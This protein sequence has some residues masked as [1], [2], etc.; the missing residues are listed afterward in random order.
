MVPVGAINDLRI[1]I[2]P[3]SAARPGFKAKYHVKYENSGTTTITNGTVKLVKDNRTT[4][5]TATTTPS[6]IVA[7]TITWTFSNLKPL[8]TAELTVELQLGAPPALNNSDTLEHYITIDPATGDSTPLNNRSD[9]KQP[10]TGSYDPNDKT[11]SHGNGFDEQMLVDGE[12]LNYVIRFQNTGNDTAFRVL[13]RDTLNNRMDWN[14]FEMISASHPYTLS[15]TNQ[16]K[17]EWKFDP[18]VLPDSTKDLAASNGYVSFRIKPKSTLVTGDTIANRAGIYFDFNPPVITNK[19]E[20][21]IAP[22]TLARP[23]INGLVAEYCRKAQT[24]TGKI[25]NL[26]PANTGVTTTVKLDNTTLTVAADGSFGFDLAALAAGDHT[27]SV[28]FNLGS[29]NMLTE[30]PF[31]VTEPGVLSLNL[32]ANTTNV[33]NASQS[34]I[35]TG[36][37]A[38]GGTN[39][40]YTYA[41]DRTFT[42]ILQA[43]GSNNIVTIDPAN[44]NQG[45]NWIYGRISANGQC[46]TEETNIDSIQIA[47][48]FVTGVVDMDAPGRSINIYP[49]PFNDH[50]ILKGFS[51]SKKYDVVLVNAQG[52]Q[53]YSAT[54]K[55]RDMHEFKTTGLPAGVY[56]VHLYKNGKEL[57]AVQVVKQ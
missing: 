39:L 51:L 57:G 19:E 10:V 33:T 5:S 29:T 55:N 20:T 37:N 13:V 16:N 27:V 53:L 23:A 49:V 8:Q 48:N 46:Y 24:I 35:I 3:V 34:V 31:H 1:T 26:Q 2:V 9:I 32:S 56:V 7:D 4:F 40:R 18:I 44:L 11:E 43:E 15:I 41:K 17:L 38:T 47:V 30:F 36:V 25:A 42:N 22:P 50:L 52:S 14:S 6:G 21:I 28:K 45:N 54:I 12:Y